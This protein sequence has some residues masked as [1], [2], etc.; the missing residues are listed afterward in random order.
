M[1][2][3]FLQGAIDRGHFHVWTLPVPAVAPLSFDFSGTA[4]APALP[5][6]AFTL[7]TR[8]SKYVLSSLSDMDD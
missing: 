8:D 5:V 7:M 6:L 3:F 2:I 4:I 1:N